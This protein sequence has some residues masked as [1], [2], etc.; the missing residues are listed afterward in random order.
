MMVGGYFYDQ[1]A[2]SFLIYTPDLTIEKK[3]NLIILPHSSALGNKHFLF[4]FFG[5][6]TGTGRNLNYNLLY[7]KSKTLSLWPDP[8]SCRTY[9]TASDKIISICLK[10]TATESQTAL[11]K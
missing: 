7:Y 8:Q 3:S 2:F 5:Y 9:S 11:A 1:S 4:C 6:K 10:F